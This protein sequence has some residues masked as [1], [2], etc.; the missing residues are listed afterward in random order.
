VTTTDPKTDTQQKIQ[1]QPPR[2]TYDILP[3]DTER[4]QWL[5]ARFKAVIQRAGYQEIRLPIFEHTELFKRGVGETTDIVNKEMYTFL[6]KSERSLTLRPEGTAGVVRAYLHHGLSRKTPPVK[7]WYIGPMFRYERVQTGRQ[8]QFHQI[9]V[10]A[11]GSAGPAIDAE[12]IVLAVDC[13]QAIGLTNIKVHLN[14][15]GCINCRP[16]FRQKLKDA[17]APHLSELCEDCKERFERNPLRML[18]CKHEHCQSFYKDL[19][20]SL[21]NLDAECRDHFQGLLALLA[22]AGVEPVINHRLVRGLDYYGRTVFELIS[23]D[24]RL[25]AQSTVGAGGRY[26]YLVES[27]GGD[28]TPAVG[29]AF[30]LE[31][32]SLLAGQSDAGNLTAFIVSDNTEAAFRLL[33][34]LRR[35]GVAADMDYPPAGAKTRAWKRQLEKAS[36][37]GAR[38]ALLLGE[39]ELKDSTVTVKLLAKQTQETIS[40]QELIGYLQKSASKGV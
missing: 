26:D 21:D 35:S 8:R 15:I 28:P 33:I 4:W 5:E 39:Q 11:F 27:L 40:M 34:E 30:G 19:P 14:S 20:T 7:L 2:G 9:G 10:E 32:L 12:S 29:W 18:D 13:L 25:G 22:T 1:I 31:R 17:I 3:G 24:E 6:D 36:K 37:T 23:D 38:F 16:V